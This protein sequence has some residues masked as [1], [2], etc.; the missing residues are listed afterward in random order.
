MRVLDQ[1][2]RLPSI[3]LQRGKRAAASCGNRTWVG[4]SLGGIDCGV[5][6]SLPSQR[7]LQMAQA[8]MERLQ[9]HLELQHFLQ[10][11]HELDGWVAE[12]Q[13]L[14]AGEA[15]RDETR[16]QQQQQQQQPRAPK[17]WLR[18]RAFMAELARNKEWLRKIEKNSEDSSGSDEDRVELRRDLRPAR[19]ASLC[20][21]LPGVLWCQG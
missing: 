10:N 17:R 4:L 14:M 11:C 3:W 20:Q 12:K 19:K 16:Q 18:H 7:N 1:N 8:W 6:G 2:S 21:G 13:A 15:S 5:F 9:V